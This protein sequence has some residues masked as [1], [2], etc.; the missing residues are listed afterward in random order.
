M[1][2]ILVIDDSPTVVLSVSRLLLGDGHQVETVTSVQELPRYLKET[3]PDLILLDLEMPGL[4]GVGWVGAMRR[5]YEGRLAVVIHSAQP[6]KKLEEAS[7]E[8]D[9]VGIIPKGASGDATRCIINS[10]L[11]RVT[12]MLG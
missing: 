6:W 11:R 8:V 9:A 12:R 3:R 1:A 7:R 2:R 5:C 4:S 10:A